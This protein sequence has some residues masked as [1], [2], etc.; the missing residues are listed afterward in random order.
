MGTSLEDGVTQWIELGRRLTLAA[1][2]LKKKK[3]DYAM[4][5]QKTKRQNQVQEQSKC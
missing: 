5:R 2:C 4:K 1:N 3:K